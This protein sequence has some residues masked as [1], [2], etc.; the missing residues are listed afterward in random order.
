LIK[1][2]DFYQH[3]ATNII[4]EKLNNKLLDKFKNI[5]IQYNILNK[6]FNF[7]DKLNI[8]HP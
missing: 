6:L 1:I 8:L 7:D 4:T 3:E 5:D 2:F